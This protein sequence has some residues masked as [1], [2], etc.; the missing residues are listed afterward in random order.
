MGYILTEEELI[1]YAKP[2]LKGR[3]FKKKNKRWTND[4]GDFTISFYFQGRSYSKK[5]DR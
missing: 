3:R 5:E 4:I 1:A 2:Y